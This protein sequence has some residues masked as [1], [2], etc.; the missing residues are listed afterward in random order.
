[1]GHV[2]R[3]ERLEGE[4]GRATAL[5]RSMVL[6][7]NVVEISAAANQIAAIGA[8]KGLNGLAVLIDS[9]IKIVSATSNRN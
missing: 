6:L 5:N 2:G 1:M 7:Y 9:P 3:R 4:H 8:E